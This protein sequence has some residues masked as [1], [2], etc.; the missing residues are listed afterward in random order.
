LTDGGPVSQ[1]AATG[2]SEGG[3]VQ[4]SRT[5][6]G[7]GRSGC[8]R[9]HATSTARPSR[10]TGS[11]PRSRSLGAV[12]GW[13]GDDTAAGEVLA[14]SGLTTTRRTPRRIPVQIG[15]IGAHGDGATI[16]VQSVGAAEP[17]PW[18]LMQSCGVI[19]QRALPGTPLERSTP[20]LRV[21]GSS[22]DSRGSVP[23]RVARCP[24][25]PW[26]R[27]GAGVRGF[28]REL[29]AFRVLRSSVRS[30]PFRGGAFRA[31][32]SRTARPPRAGTR[33]RASRRRGPG[34]PASPRTAPRRPGR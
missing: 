18:S 34:P 16:S 25:P 27:W 11:R 29:R 3:G 12:I 15:A 32:V 31:R 21:D 14:T 9:E 1:G 33:P 4:R 28:S 19:R 30:G 23:G 26:R 22:V 24:V 2:G 6:G 13:R 7:G 8:R 5:E 10:A 20:G 17:G